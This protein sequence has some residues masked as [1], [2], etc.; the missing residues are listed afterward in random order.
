MTQP[1]VSVVIP[2]RDRP[3]L[4]LRAVH[5][6]LRQTLPSLEL[7]V[8]QDGED[9]ETFSALQTVA[10]PRLRVHVAPRGY[11]PGAVRNAGVAQARAEWIA[12]LDDDDEML[13]ERLERQLEAG[14]ALG[15]ANPVVLC[16]A[17]VRTPAG[18]VVLPEVL[19]TFSEH[20]SDF[21]FVKKNILGRSGGLG[22]SLVFTRKALL[23][24]VPFPNLPRHEDWAWALKALSLPGSDYT[25]V[26]EPLVIY[27][28]AEERPSL[29]RVIDWRYS[30]GWAGDHRKLMT[31]RA[32]VSFLMSTVARLARGQAAYGAIP[33]LLGEV[34]QCGRPRPLDCA[35]FAAIWALPGS[36][37]GVVSSLRRIRRQRM[38]ER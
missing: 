16:R 19:P 1:R 3:Q 36:S 7:L 32:Y 9:A 10:D 22:A 26:S 27:H 33:K 34:F 21:I 14:E 30:Y 35:L 2:T 29:S 11:G 37:H 25:M 4:V 18:D 5:S 6:V 20:I 17:I 31:D 38:T 12:F 28:L 15:V 13:P 8:V 24:A 23:Q